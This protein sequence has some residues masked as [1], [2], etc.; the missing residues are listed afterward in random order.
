[1]LF[2]PTDFRAP[3]YLRQQ[4][5]NHR[6]NRAA[7]VIGYPAGQ[8]QQGWTERWAFANDSLDLANTLGAG[9]IDQCHDGGQ[10]ASVSERHAHAG[11]NAHPIS[12][13]LRNCVIQLSS[14]GTIHDHAG[15]A[16]QFHLLAQRRRGFIP[17]MIEAGICNKL[18]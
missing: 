9:L 5:T 8:L 6:F 15:E 14:N 7:I 16:A 1:M 18:A 4:A 3:D 17:S 12:Q 13:D 2:F 10:R 11:T